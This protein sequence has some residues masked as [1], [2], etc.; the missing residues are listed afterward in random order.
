MIIRETERGNVWGLRCNYN[1]RSVLTV[2][3]DVGA[4]QPPKIDNNGELPMEMAVFETSLYR[5]RKLP[6]ID[7]KLKERVFIQVGMGPH[8]DLKIF[9]KDCWA[10]P[11]ENHTH[12][13]R[14]NLIEEGCVSDSTLT[15]YASGGSP[16]ARF[17]YQ[18]FRFRG[19]YDRAFI[20]CEVLV[21]QLSDA[22]SRC[23]RGCERGLRKKRRVIQDFYAREE[24]SLGPFNLVPEQRTECPPIANFS[25]GFTD[26]TNGFAPE[27]VCNF[28]CNQGFYLS[29]LPPTKKSIKC[30]A[31]NESKWDHAT[32][33]CED[34]NECT[35]NGVDPCLLGASFAY[36]VCRNVPGYYVCECR[37]GFEPLPG[38]PD[39]CSTGTSLEGTI[40]FDEV[41]PSALADPQSDITAQMTSALTESMN[42][43]F[44][45]IMPETRVRF[46]ITGFSP[47]SIVVHYEMF[48]FQAGTGRI[49][50]TMNQVKSIEM[51]MRRELKPTNISGLHL[52]PAENAFELADKNEC[53][54]PKSNDCADAATCVNT[55]GSFTCKC[56]EGFV[57]KGE[58]QGENHFP[59]R[60]CEIQRLQDTTE[61]RPI[62]IHDDDGKWKIVAYIMTGLLLVGFPLSLIIIKKKYAQT[63]SKVVP[64]P[65]GRVNSAFAVFP[66]TMAPPNE[67]QMP[68]QQNR[69]HQ[70]SS[71]KKYST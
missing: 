44:G 15:K 69:D 4:W 31:A 1:R 52:V 37:K 12:P 43:L 59:G 33:T 21:C 61:D 29:G 68:H 39:K 64:E 8:E 58:N 5:S 42:N 18:A 50:D 46:Q 3:K 10:T 62:K 26:C 2:G 38:V 51:K 45:S 34:V 28:K 7:V 32:P 60:N 25:D 27:S 56:S 48:I 53:L 22:N 19:D 11:F 54:D 41:F 71:A 6:P 63:H 17:S 14:Y 16:Q 30:V 67:R 57:D 65:D 49:E 9:L 23:N 47:G 36:K 35:V 55:F 40:K 20:H 66:E 24:V 70:S 13:M